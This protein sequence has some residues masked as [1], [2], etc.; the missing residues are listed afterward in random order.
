MAKTA[1]EARSTLRIKEIHVE[2]SFP[3]SN[4]SRAIF[5]FIFIQSKIFLVDRLRRILWPRLFRSAMRRRR[6][7]T[8]QPRW[9]RRRGRGRVASRNPSRKRLRRKKRN[10]R[11]KKPSVRRARWK[12]RRRSTSTRTMERMRIS[13]TNKTPKEVL[14]TRELEETILFYVKAKERNPFADLSSIDHGRVSSDLLSAHNVAFLVDH[15][16]LR[17]NRR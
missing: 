5:I 12:S 1:A 3:D 10:S 11:G 14:R 15:E 17:R 9:S 6:P 7:S 13:S 4:N 16:R 8:A 2:V